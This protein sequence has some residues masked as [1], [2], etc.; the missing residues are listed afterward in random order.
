MH[1]IFLIT[2]VI[3]PLSVY[4]NKL[5]PFF[6]SLIIIHNS[7]EAI[8]FL[9]YWIIITELNLTRNDSLYMYN[10]RTLKAYMYQSSHF[11]FQQTGLCKGGGRWLRKLHLL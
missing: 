8:V 9:R 7:A 11:Y 1:F 5:D 10:L 6:Y 4:Q 2:V 3:Q